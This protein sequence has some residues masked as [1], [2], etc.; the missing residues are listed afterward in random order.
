[1]HVHLFII[2][3]FFFFQAEDGIRDVAV[4]GVQTCALPISGCSR[5]QSELLSILVCTEEMQRHV[6]LG[7]LD[8]AVVTRRD[9]EQ[10]AGPEGEGLAVVHDDPAAS[11]D[12]EPDVLDLT[13]LGPHDGA[14]VR[15]PLPPRV[16]AGAPDGEGADPDEIELS[17][18]EAARLV[19]PVESSD[20][21]VF[22]AGPLHPTRML[23]STHFSTSSTSQAASGLQSNPPANGSTRRIGSTS[24]S[25][26]A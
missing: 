1:M 3:F 14:D 8:P 19:G 6:R 17:L 13:A 23:S 4:T 10:V 26:S 15:G 9:V 20:D 12:D 22:H 16:I 24:Q 7:A 25:V 18:L 2:F 21:R 11:R 5:A